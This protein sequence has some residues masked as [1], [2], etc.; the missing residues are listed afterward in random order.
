MNPVLQSPSFLHEPPR[1]DVGVVRGGVVVL[2][3]PLVV[4][5]VVVFLRGVVLK[6][7]PLVVSPLPLVVF[8][9]WVVVF[10]THL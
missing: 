8:F 5:S 3:N 6:V 9:G 1:G 10:G 7:N 2:M 4:F